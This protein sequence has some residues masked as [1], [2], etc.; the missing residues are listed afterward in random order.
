MSLR[1]RTFLLVQDA[2]PVQSAVLSGFDLTE[3][4]N[5][6]WYGTATVT[7]DLSGSGAPPAG[8]GSAGAGGTLAPPTGGSA[9]GGSGGGGSAGA[10]GTLAPPG[11][12]GDTA[13][14]IT[15]GDM[16]K[17][18]L[19]KS[20]EPGSPVTL[21]LVY[22]PARTTPPA[23][24]AGTAGAAG[25]A[26]SSLSGAI[27][28]AWPCVI[29]ALAPSQSGSSTK[30]T[31][32]I[33][34]M[35]PISYLSGRPVWGVYRACSIGAMIG[36][37]LS[38]AAGGDGKPTLRPILPGLPRVR[39]V[40][41]CRD[42]LSTISYSIASGESLGEWVSA[43]LGTLGVRMEMYGAANGTVYVNL[44]DR[45]P[46]G[47]IPMAVVAGIGGVSGA[48]GTS[49]DDGPTEISATRLAVTGIDG[50]AP[51]PVR[52]G[53]LD[54]AAQG[55]FRTFGRGAIGSVHTGSEI[56]IDEAV[57]RILFP[58]VTA[59]AEMVTLTTACEE[60][61]F[62]PGR[63]TRLDTAYLG[64]DVWQIANVNHEVAGTSYWNSATLFNGSVAWHPPQP[65]ARPPRIVS[66]VIDGG[67]ND[68]LYH[69]PVPRDRIGRIPVSISFVPTPTGPDA[70][71]LDA[72]D[73]DDD[74]Q[75]TLDDFDQPQISDYTDNESDWE[76]DAEDYFDGE[77]DDP[78]DGRDD[79]DL[80]PAEL[81]N[82]RRLEAKRR[83]VVRY[84][85]YKRAKRRDSLDRDQDGYLSSRD[86]AISPELANLL[87][88]PA[89]R[90]KL[91]AEWRQIRAGTYNPTLN[92]ASAARFRLVREY[93][94]YFTDHLDGNGSGAA[95]GSGASGSTGGSGASG[96]TG[97]SGASGSAAGAS[98][99]SG[100][101]GASGASGE[102]RL[103]SG[104]ELRNR[105]TTLN[106][107]FSLAG[108]S[109]ST[110]ASGSSGTSASNPITDGTLASARAARA[111]AD[112]ADERWPPR[113]PLTV[114]EPM[115]GG[116]HG[117]IPAH[118]QGDICRIAVHHPMHAEIVGF[119]YRANRQINPELV[120]TTAGFVVE[121]DTRSAW[122]GV[123]F[124][125]LED[126]VGEEGASGA[127][128]SSGSR[129]GSGPLG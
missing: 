108:S 93:G 106:G 10:G 99:A 101:S 43:M 66:G 117:F 78:Y 121:H 11:G 52:S 97:G 90:A 20:M 46:S 64:Q 37:A 124:R 65:P 19:D 54:D 67:N 109:G 49:D 62:R 13:E 1:Y 8:G 120:E 40:E 15:V 102:E 41:N 103:A 24:T 4:Y 16:L 47:E 39:I 105:L 33:V 71:L 25:S 6:G 118:R 72:A 36:G 56:G 31:C 32:G 76:D 3:E 22:A 115:A 9:G 125:P 129:H 100:S 68:Y 73:T 128:G 29:S 42:A 91:E 27:I 14:D 114:V 69:E 28:R 70:A 23:G 83:D 59:N 127:S 82:R 74:G 94:M 107:V 98:G 53:V 51:L 18:M 5:A 86:S 55:S 95:G 75:L 2:N 21:Y 79:D 35:D 77:L 57:K 7:V 122:S 63:R 50:Y 44:T 80:T 85:A 104:Q 116:L 92:A 123:V 112:V 96:S 113:V 81:A 126:L 61:N 45:V 119:Q 26:G 60:P 30:A 111:D 88:D 48:S 87:D 84:L 12:S 58:T 17:I 110:G 34:L 38:L 89:E